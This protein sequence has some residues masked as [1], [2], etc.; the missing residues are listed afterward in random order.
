MPSTN[1]TVPAIWML[2]QL[3]LAVTA[4]LRIAPAATRT[5][6]E[7]TVMSRVIPRFYV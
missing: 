6:D 7:P 1:S 5:I 3:T 2:I 4:H